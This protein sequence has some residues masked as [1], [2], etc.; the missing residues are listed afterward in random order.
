V[1]YTEGTSVNPPEV[2]NSMLRCPIALCTS[3]IYFKTRS[4][5]LLHL[6]QAH[7]TEGLLDLFPFVKSQPCKICVDE[8]R[9][10]VLIAQIKNRH[11]AHIGVNH[12]IVLDLLPAE[13]KEVLMVLPRR[14][15]QK[16]PESVAVSK[17]DMQITLDEAPAPSPSPLPPPTSFPSSNY[18]YNFAANTNFPQ[19]NQ[20]I[21]SYTVPNSQSNTNYPQ[22]N[23]S[24]SSYPQPNQSNG[25]YQDQS[26]FPPP[27]YTPGSY[28]PYPGY[29][30]YPAY[31]NYSEYSFDGAAPN[32]VKNESGQSAMKEESGNLIKEEPKVEIKQEP[33]DHSETVY[34]CSICTARSFNQRSDLLFH[35]SITH[36]SR[37]LNQLYPFKDNQICS[38]CNQF[39][40]KNMSSHI[41]HVGLKHEEVIKFLPPD[42]AATLVPAGD[43]IA[44][45][46]TAI[47]P[48]EKTL[49]STSVMPNQAT[50]LP[51][52]KPVQK[53][54]EVAVPVATTDSE[55]P[56]VQCSMCLANNKQ[57]LF[58]K[59]SEF[60]KHLS[61][62]HYGK[63]LLQAFPFAEGKNC[64]LCFETSK[65]M[66]TPSKK[67]VHV[68][69]VGVLHAKIFELLPKEILQQVMEMPTMKKVVSN[70]AL[71]RVPQ[72]QTQQV[73][74]QEPASFQP[75][76]GSEQK[77][78]IPNQAPASDGSNTT[79]AF[80]SQPPS[81]S[82]TDTS[83]SST[84]VA[85]PPPTA[86]SQPAPPS[87][88][89]PVPPRDVPFKTPASDQFKIPQQ[90]TDKPY[91]CRYCVSG[92]DVA[93][94]LKD[95][96]L[97]HKSQFSQINQTPRKGTP[98][99][100]VHLRM[101]TPR[102]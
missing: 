4:E 32:Q 25:S 66:Y 89:N 9:P 96:L 8:K 53:P 87:F 21:G 48:L 1:E 7:Y 17:P 92:F 31:P 2:D 63:A 18:N 75:S 83:S 12:E 50:Q 14:I 62:L 95:H 56:S 45:Q 100:L 57:R 5:I 90:K 40:P 49:E 99:S 78:V 33:M 93:K 77:D 79:P 72:V 38:L 35:L 65:K 37:N 80:S 85:P 102:K 44:H 69:H 71:D 15:R 97:T 64:N 10:K 36:F 16:R 13:L 47:K 23:Q 54:T 39:K 24:N 94:D 51:V 22:P 58:T 84:F 55:E 46:D 82:T 70:S 86:F 59:R 98:S 76:S 27:T 11:V 101:N 67:E 60:L 68:C 28:P 73:R 41:S 61:L 81:F 52:E 43:S 6:T 34:K 20:S 19:T 88:V 3:E 91:N 74:P 26:S 30:Q 42:L 29:S